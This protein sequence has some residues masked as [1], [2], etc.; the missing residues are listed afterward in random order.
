MLVMLLAAGFLSGFIDS[1]VGGGGLISLPV[2][3]LTGLPVTTALGSNKLAASTGVVTSGTIYWRRGHV[4]KEV[5][6][7]LFFPVFFASMFGSYIVTQIPPLYLEPIIVI[8]L[9]IV[10]TLVIFRKDWG[11]VSTV[12]STGGKWFFIAAAC[13]LAIGF[14]DGFIGPGTGTFL[15]FTFVVLGL[16]FLEASGNSRCLNMA[17]NLGSL[18]FFLFMGKVNFLYGLSMAAGMALGGYTGANLAISKGARFVRYI[19]I[20]VTIVLILHLARRVWG[21]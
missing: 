1:I 20:A 11:T 13:S 12:Q 19:F 17:S 15:M 5:V 8:V 4:R 3:L 14:Y 21:G 18:V 7:P 16:D 6:K 2:M 9:S 10:A